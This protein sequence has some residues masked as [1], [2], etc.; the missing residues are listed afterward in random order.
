MKEITESEMLQ[1]IRCKRIRKQ[2]RGRRVFDVFTGLQGS[3][4][5]G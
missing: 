4:H 2:N 5:C 3:C 1:K